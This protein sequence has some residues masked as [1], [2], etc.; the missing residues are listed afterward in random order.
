MIAYAL[1]LLIVLMVG[2][3][4]GHL[5]YHAPHRSYLRRMRR[6]DRYYAQRSAEADRRLEQS[7]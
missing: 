3:F 7:A 4:I 5:I 6:D 2:G 1:I